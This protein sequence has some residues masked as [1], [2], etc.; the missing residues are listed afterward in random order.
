MNCFFAH[1]F[2]FLKIM[3]QLNHIK[4]FY[5]KC[6]T[7]F[8]VKSHWRF[9]CPK[10]NK[11]HKSQM[12]NEVLDK[13][14]MENGVLWKCFQ[15]PC[16]CAW[17]RCQACW[18]GL[19][20]AAWVKLNCLRTGVGQFHLSMHKWGLAPSPNC[21]CGTSE[22]TAD[23]VLTACPIHQAPHG[24]RGLMVLNDKT[25]CWLNDITTSIWSRQCSSL[26]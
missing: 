12:E 11:N 10:D 2:K 19:P 21:E 23:H 14:Q 5:Q 25:R 4:V 26:G 22:Q 20:W 16:F 24:V 6:M 1:L 13:S 7:L 9:Y 15:A 3:T 17:D 18:D 8:L